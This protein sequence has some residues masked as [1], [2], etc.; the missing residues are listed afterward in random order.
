[1]ALHIFRAGP[2][3]VHFST[4]SAH[5]E[6]HRSAIVRRNELEAALRACK[7]HKRVTIQGQPVDELQVC[8]LI[9]ALDD[10]E[11]PPLF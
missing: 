8:A 7:G 5:H 4:T 10:S 3:W 9:Q 6:Q 1:M 11:Q 2:N